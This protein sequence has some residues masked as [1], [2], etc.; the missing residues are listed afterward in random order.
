MPDAKIDFDAPDLA[1]RIE[2][3]SHVQIDRLPFGVIL[4][5]PEGVVKFYSATE[6]RQSG[7]GDSPVGLN[8]FAVARCSSAELL[9]ARIAATQEDSPVNLEFA[10]KGNY[11]DPNRDARVRVQS[12][13]QG[14]IWLF[15]ERD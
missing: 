10:W 2:R 9:Q 3:L 12:A 7:Y 5:D 14:G 4:L 1:A 6:A 11:V 15:I 13:R 8:F